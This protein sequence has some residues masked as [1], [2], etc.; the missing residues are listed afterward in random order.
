MRRGGRQAVAEELV[1]PNQPELEPSRGFYARVAG[2][3]GPCSPRPR[4][5]IFSAVTAYSPR[6]LGWGSVEPSVLPSVWN[7]KTRLETG[8][9]ACPAPPWLSWERLIQG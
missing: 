1:R 8:G 3:K 4:N 7:P 2:S 5:P 6:A 9:E